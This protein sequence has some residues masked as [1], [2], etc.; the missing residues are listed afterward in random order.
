M[1]LDGIFLETFEFK[2]IK[3]LNPAHLSRAIGR[4]AGKDGRTIRAIMDAS[5]TRIVLAD[6]KVHIM[7]SFQNIRIARET[8]VSL[9]LGAPPG[10]IYNNLKIISRRMKESF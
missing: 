1:R 2:D 4:V 6:S 10:K 5:K 8:V 7:G 3:T 9:V